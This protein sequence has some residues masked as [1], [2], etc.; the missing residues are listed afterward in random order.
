LTLEDFQKRVNTLT[1][2]DS[3]VGRAVALTA[4]Y[5][6]ETAHE[7]APRKTGN[8]ARSILA[9]V[10]DDL[11]FRLQATAKYAGI[12]EYGGTIHGNRFLRFQGRGGKWATVRKVKIPARPFLRPAMDKAPDYLRGRLEELMKGLLK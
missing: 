8:L 5:A 1:G 11:S 7:L 12:Q 6:Q 3:A 10:Q 2:R 9:D 4:K